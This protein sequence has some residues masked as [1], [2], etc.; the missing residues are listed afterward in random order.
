MLLP[1]HLTHIEDTLR[2]DDGL[3]AQLFERH[4]AFDVVVETNDTTKIFDA[5][6]VTVGD[7]SRTCVVIAEEQRQGAFNQRLLSGQGQLF[8]LGIYRQHLR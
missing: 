3:R 8:I 1:P 7:A 5:H 2:T 6:N 4:Q